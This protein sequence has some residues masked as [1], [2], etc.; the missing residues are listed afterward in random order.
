MYEKTCSNLFIDHCFIRQVYCKC[1]LHY[2]WESHLVAAHTAKQGR[3]QDFQIGGVQKIVRANHK[4]PYGRGPGPAL[5]TWRLQSFNRYS[6]YAIRDLFWSILIQ[7]GIKNTCTSQSKFRGGASLLLRRLD[8]PLAKYTARL[9]TGNTE[10]HTNFYDW[11]C[12]Y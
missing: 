9:Y 7:N 2:S 8:P 6:H 10:G 5:G 11:M 3:I 12:V 4:V 1:K